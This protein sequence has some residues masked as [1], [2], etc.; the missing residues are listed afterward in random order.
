M[1]RRD[2]HRHPSPNSGRCE[3]AFAGALGVRLGGVNHYG[4][5]V[6]HRPELGDG[7]RP[8]A[9][10]IRRSVRLT[11]AVSLAALA[12][13]TGALAAAGAIRKIRNG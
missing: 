12:L 8:D 11:R 4:G 9:A 5:R 1:L 7:P 6:E 3:A 2:G 10:D 13:T